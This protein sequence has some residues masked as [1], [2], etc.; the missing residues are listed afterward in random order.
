M[1]LKL[2]YS[3]T[4]KVRTNLL[5]ITNLVIVMWNWTI[6]CGAETVWVSV[7]RVK[8]V[9]WV[10]CISLDSQIIEKD[11]G[12]RDPYGVRRKGA[13]AERRLAVRALKQSAKN[14]LPTD[15]TFNHFLIRNDWQTR[16]ALV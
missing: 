11:T 8:I 16:N 6:R 1:T 4:S 7:E 5:A 3:I 14:I 13:Q 12:P 2:L 10:R 9:S 15:N